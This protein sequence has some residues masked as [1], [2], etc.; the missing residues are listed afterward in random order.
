MIESILSK[1]NSKLQFLYRKQKFLIKNIRRLLYNSL[2]QPDY[3]FACCSWYPILTLG[4]KD[5]IQI[6]QNECIQFCF[7]DRTDGA[8]FIE[9][10]WLPVDLRVEQCICAPIYKYLNND[11]P[12]YIGE[13][14]T[15][16][17]A[18]YNTRDPQKFNHP[19]YS[20]SKGQKAIS[21]VGPTLWDEKPNVL[22]QKESIASFKHDF[23]KYFLNK[24]SR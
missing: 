21:Y 13:M 7:R 15:V 9:I 24:L 8:R 3:N 11:V 1:I 5:W 12:A 19:Q 10:N 2:I 14:F 23:K 4:L 22:K 20:T 17:V 6:S 16:N 18:K